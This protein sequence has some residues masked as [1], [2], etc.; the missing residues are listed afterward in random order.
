MADEL[1]RLVVCLV[2]GWRGEIGR[3]KLSKHVGGIVDCPK[4]GSP[5]THFADG[6]READF[7]SPVP[8]SERH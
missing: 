5:E 8:K 2:C 6:V 7:P 1:E 4:C 3:M